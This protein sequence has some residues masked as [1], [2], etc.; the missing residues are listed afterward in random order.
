M[1][2]PER[3]FGRPG[4]NWITS[5]V[6]IGPISW[7]TQCDQFLAQMFARLDA[8]H[9]RHIGVDAL[10]LDVVRIADDGGLARPSHARRARS[11]PPPCRGDGPRH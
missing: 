6:A 3:V 9:Q 1:I 11:R 7:R 4:A 10:A 2:L 5:G 8:V